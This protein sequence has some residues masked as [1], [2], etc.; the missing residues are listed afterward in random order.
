MLNHISNI[1]LDATVLQI[2]YL[3]SRYYLNLEVKLVLVAQGLKIY[4]AH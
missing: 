1:C 4:N 2:N 3:K